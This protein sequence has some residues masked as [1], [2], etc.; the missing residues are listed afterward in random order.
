M[1]EN[2]EALTVFI[3]GSLALLTIRITVL[4]LGRDVTRAERN[5]EPEPGVAADEQSSAAAPVQAA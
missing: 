2:L 4:L 1:A 3:S 5:P